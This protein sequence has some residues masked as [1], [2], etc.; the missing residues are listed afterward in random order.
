MLLHG[1]AD[2]TAIW[3]RV[4]GTLEARGQLVL[5]DQRAH[6]RSSAPPGPVTRDDLAADVVAVLDHLGIERAML[7]GHSMGGIVAMT[8]A[9]AAPERIAG[10]VLIGT[11][12]QVSARA[13]AWY[14]KIA[15]A[16]ER[17]GIPGLR[18]AIFGADSE[19]PIEGDARGMAAI[20][21]ALAGLHASPLTPHLA[22]VRCPTL[23]LVGDRD[24]MGPAA[25]E[26]IHRAIPGSTFEVVPGGH[27]LHVEAPERV[28]EA[29][30]RFT[31]PSTGSG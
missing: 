12:S 29:I 18:R 3:R 2:T 17:E 30:E 16:A 20:T 21:R 1:L 7:L 4:A 27:W 28:L 22:A 13:A 8:T 26:I 14:G 9:L 10:L 11:A 31:R 19:R 25:S 6:G 15:E 23:L 5:V 24:P